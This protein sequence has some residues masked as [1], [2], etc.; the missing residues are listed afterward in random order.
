[1]PGDCTNRNKGSQ[2]EVTAVFSW[3]RD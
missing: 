1:M 2:I 3:L